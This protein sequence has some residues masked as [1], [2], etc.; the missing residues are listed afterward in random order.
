[1]TRRHRSGF[2]MIE[3]LLILAILALLIGL[4]LPAVQSVRSASARTQSLNNMKMIGLS[5]HGYHDT[6]KTLPSAFAKQPNIKSPV[7]IHVQLLPFM[8][9]ENLYNKY[10]QKDGGEEASN[11]MVPNFMSPQDASLG[12]DS[13]GIQNYAANLRVFCDSGQMTKFN[14]DMPKIKEI[15]GLKNP[16][17]LANGFPDGCSNTVV[18]STKIGICGE[19]GSKYVS[20]PNTKT[21]AFFGQN[22]AQ[23]KASPHSAKATFQL[24]PGP[25]EGLISPLMAQSFAKEGIIVGLADA[26]ARLVS[27]TISPDTWNAAL[28]PRDGMVLGNDW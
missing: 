8:E 27:N 28:C 13:K 6:Y 12:K 17:T 23:E 2:T 20:A 22:A 1:M 26:S 3:V 16:L 18:Y 5:L 24:A 19:G 25:K 9:Q 21:A 11:A 14:E 10:A 7:S 4:L 15:E